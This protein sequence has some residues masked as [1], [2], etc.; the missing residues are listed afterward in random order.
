MF[1][2]ILRELV[3]M[4]AAIF[5]IPQVIEERHEPLLS[6][7]WDWAEMHRNND[8]AAIEYDEW[9]NRTQH[10]RGLVC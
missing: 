8:F 7:W 6:I 1:E 4:S 10:P 3:I 5:F 2:I 9:S